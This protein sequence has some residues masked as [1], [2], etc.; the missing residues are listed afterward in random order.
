M[1]FFNL[2]A[3]YAL[4][5]LSPG[6]HPMSLYREA[7]KAQGILGS[8][9]LASSTH[10]ITVK[11][12]GQVVMHQAPPTAKDFH[13]VTLEDSDGMMNVIVRP[14]VY[15]KYKLVLRSVPLLTVTGE[16]QRDG[17]VVNLIAHHI[18]GL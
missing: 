13:F 10:G 8:K 9:Q 3:E 16:V 11:V 1:W 2:T 4:L 6:D 5:G 7:L 14:E 17:A 18:A 15:E 12:A